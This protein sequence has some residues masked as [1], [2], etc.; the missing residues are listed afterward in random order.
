MAIIVMRRKRANRRK[1]PNKIPYNKNDQGK[2]INPPVFWRSK[3]R[4]QKL[5]GA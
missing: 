5:I 3:D 1:L 2:L 4:R